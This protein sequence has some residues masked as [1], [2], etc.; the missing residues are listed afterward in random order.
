MTL[1]TT[2]G[3]TTAASHEDALASILADVLELPAVD[4]EARYLDLGGNSISLYLVIERVKSELGIELD[5]QQFFDPDHSS[6]AAIARSMS[7]GRAA[8]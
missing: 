1:T 2:N 6:I 3:G 8:A 5:P 4:R 7:G